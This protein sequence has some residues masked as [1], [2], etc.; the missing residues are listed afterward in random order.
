MST[1]NPRGR[2]ESPEKSLRQDESWINTAG[3]QLLSDSSSFNDKQRAS[4]WTIGWRTP[5]LI[6]TFYV[7]GMSSISQWLDFALTL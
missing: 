5:T 4:T 1:L 2:S 3:M 7:S 6:F